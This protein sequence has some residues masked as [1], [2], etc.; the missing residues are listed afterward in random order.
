V[1]D[2]RSDSE[3]NAKKFELEKENDEAL[4]KFEKYDLSLIEKGQK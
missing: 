4:K 1:K 2:I 3:A